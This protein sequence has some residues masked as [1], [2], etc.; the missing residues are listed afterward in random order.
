MPFV[1]GAGAALPIAIGITAVA[2][3]AIGATLSL[4][5][6]RGAVL[7]GARMLAQEPPQARSRLRSGH[8][9]GVAVG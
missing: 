9:V 5:T 7:S 6:G 2:L 8:F 3:F 1:L 4:Y